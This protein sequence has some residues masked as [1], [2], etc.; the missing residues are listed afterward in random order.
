MKR[1]TKIMIY[2][3]LLIVLVAMSLCVFALQRNR[4][5]FGMFGKWTQIDP[6]DVSDPGR[7]TVMP[8]V[9]RYSVWSDR[10]TCLYT[11]KSYHGFGLDGA[12][13]IVPRT[14]KV[15][16]EL[17]V[18][19]QYVDGRNIRI[20][21]LCDFEYDGRG[22]IVTAE[23]VKT[24]DMKYLPE[25][26]RSDFCSS[27]NDYVPAPDYKV[28]DIILDD[29]RDALFWPGTVSDDF[30][31]EYDV[32]LSDIGF[33][34]MTGMMDGDRLDVNVITGYEDDQRIIR[35]V[36]FLTELPVEELESYIAE[37]LIPSFGISITDGSEG[38]ILKYVSGS[39]TVEIREDI[40]SGFNE[41]V[42]T[43][44]VKEEE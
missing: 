1:E 32:S 29:I 11:L 3:I 21:S 4:G 27:R 42:C 18:H 12:F 17:V 8:F 16:G 37:R 24:K 13:E 26:F 43:V 7:M 25:G 9:M 31:E 15:S 39:Y 44:P 6:Y 33:C 38:R 23:F 2:K 30:Y 22:V 28:P 20:I 10:T 35:S 19:T 40:S 41:V 34:E 5:F 14:R 36:S